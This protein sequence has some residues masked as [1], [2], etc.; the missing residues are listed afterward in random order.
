MSEKYILAID[1]STSGTKAIL[2]TKDCTVHRRVTIPHKQYY[3]KPEWVE[4]DPEEI[5]RNVR[6][7]VSKV[8]QEGDAS[9]SDVAAIAV[10][11]QRETGM[12]WDGVTGKPVYNAVVWQ[13][14]RA[15][16]KCDLLARDAEIAQYIHKKTGLHISENIDRAFKSPNDLFKY[17]FIDPGSVYD[18]NLLD[19]DSFW[20]VYA[21][22]AYE[23][24]LNDGGAF[25]KKLIEGAMGNV[26][27]F[28]SF[29]LDDGYIPMMVSKYNQGENEEPYLIKKHKDGVIL[30]MH[31]PFLCQQACLVSGLTGSFSWLEGYI[32]KLER[33]FECYD[34]YYY[35]ENCGLYVWADDVMIGMDNDPAVFGRPRFSTAGIYLNSFMV[36]EM[37]SMAKILKNTA[38]NDRADYYAQ[39]AENLKAAIQNE[40]YDPRDKFFYSVD[41]KTRSYDWFH[42]GLGVFWKTLPIKIQAWTG[43]VPMYSEIA[44][45]EQAECL[46]RMHLENKNTFCSDFGVRS[47]AKDEKMYNLE[48]S[49]N[50]SNWLGPVWLVV[51][52]VVFRGLLNYGYKEEAA[53]LCNKTLLLLGEDYKKTGTLH[54]YYNPETGQPIMNPGFLNW[55]MLQLTCFWK[56]MKVSV[57][58]ITCSQY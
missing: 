23:K 20:S 38:R 55:N 26:L 7:A 15:K 44:S 58:L 35:N 21:L 18:G 32:E 57:Y 37:H 36:K 48:A 4:H 52:Y 46:V 16:E 27:N 8:M 2:F 41:V 49:I 50:P 42:K 24:T 11:N 19:W 54:E 45:G 31:K 39:K 13:C 1:Q 33:Y 43:F 10:T 12:L 28:L 5:A 29:Q 9:W 53:E 14:P 47:L 6:T 56:L 25:R 30:N 40:C 17:P 22:A 51:N 3:P 34:R